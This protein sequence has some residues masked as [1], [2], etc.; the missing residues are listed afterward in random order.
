MTETAPKTPKRVEL[1]TVIALAL[2]AVLILGAFFASTAITSHLRVINGLKDQV[3]SDLLSAVSA[4]E[5]G[6]T[7]GERF[8]LVP[9]AADYSPSQQQRQL[10]SSSTT[11]IAIKGNRAVDL[12]YVTKGSP[13]KVLGDGTVGSARDYQLTAISISDKAPNWAYTYNF[14]TKRY[15]EATLDPLKFGANLIDTTNAHFTVSRKQVSKVTNL[16]VSAQGLLT[17]QQPV[18]VAGSPELDRLVYEKYLSRAG[19]RTAF[20][21]PANDFVF[22]AADGSAVA[23]PASL[24]WNLAL[25]VAAA[26]QAS[27]IQLTAQT[28]QEISDSTLAKL[29]GGTFTFK[30]KDLTGQ[31]HFGLGVTGVN[32]NS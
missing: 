19:K 25:I 26:P 1:R 15:T 2:A 7:G 22:T 5:S 16:T 9:A 11:L 3:R 17:P 4:V 21:L 13:A 30:T 8:L 14:K 18:K 31:W 24:K 29:D 20:D 23:L 6:T 27:Q 10:T 12:I 32:I 28:P